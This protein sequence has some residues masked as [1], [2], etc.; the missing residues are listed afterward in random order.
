MSKYRFRA[1]FVTLLV[2]S[3]LGITVGW[4]AGGTAPA[5]ADYQGLLGLWESEVLED[6]Y[7]ISIGLDGLGKP[8]PARG[9]SE[10]RT[11][12]LL[13][14]HYGNLVSITGNGT[15]AIFWYQEGMGV[16]RNAIVPDANEH[17]I[18]IRLQN[19]TKLK[20]KVVRD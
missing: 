18:R 7:D 3:L 9:H 17:A 6:T 11:E 4:F 8:R 19:T 10:Q 1:S 15:A 20:T 13:P 16:I 5:S 2:G 12:L 14:Q